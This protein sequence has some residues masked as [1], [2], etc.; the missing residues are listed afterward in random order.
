MPVNPDGFV[1]DC[2]MTL[3]WC[4]ADEAS[5]LTDGV[6]DRLADLGAV[7]PGIWPLEVANVLL[8]AERRGRLDQ[9]RS[10]RFIS[11]L[12]Q[13]PIIVDVETDRRAFTEIGQVAR[14][15]DLSAYDAAYLELAIRR[16]L[17]L[18][19]KDLKL[20]KAAQAAGVPEFD[21]T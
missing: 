1:L 14:A 5:P 19:S 21:P 2:S 11:L 3:A 6:R 17:P 18:A 7:V 13:L 8:V 10:L 4:F 9:A 16:G 12:R 20:L 15:Y